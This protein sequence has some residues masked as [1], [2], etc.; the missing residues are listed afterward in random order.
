MAQSL[1]QDLSAGE[2]TAKSINSQ[3]WLRKIAAAC[4]L[5]FS[6]LAENIHQS[7]RAAARG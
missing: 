3:R 5:S 1:G 6:Q 2:S 7:R 4:S